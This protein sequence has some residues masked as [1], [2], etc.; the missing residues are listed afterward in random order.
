MWSW[1]LD[2]TRKHLST[3]WT[4]L[5]EVHL[6]YPAHRWLAVGELVHAENECMSFERTP[7]DRLGLAFSK[8]VRE[9]RLLVMKSHESSFNADIFRLIVIASLLA[10]EEADLTQFNTN[11][12][13]YDAMAQ[14]KTWVEAHTPK[15]LE[16][17]QAHIDPWS[18]ADLSFMEKSEYGLG[19]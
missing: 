19:K 14:A 4:F 13:F 18:D 6:G 16:V 11:S 3:A 10:G 12:K 5:N 17:A 8:E 2:C 9:T 1:C 7:G 15:T